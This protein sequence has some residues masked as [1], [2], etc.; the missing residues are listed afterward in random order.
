MSI[1]VLENA[2]IWLGGYDLSGQL[3]AV[4]IGLEADKHDATVFGCDGWRS[5]VAGLKS[6]N[7]G[8]VGFWEVNNDA[9]IMNNLTTSSAPFSTALLGVTAGN[10]AYCFNARTGT[11]NPYDANVGEPIK[12]TANA[13]AASDKMARGLLLAAQAIT[14]DGSGTAFQLGAV[15][16]TKKLCAA[17]HVTAWNATSLVVTLSSSSTEG[18]SYTVRGTF[19]TATAISGKWLIP[20]SGP[21]TDTWWKANWDITG[22][23]ATIAVVAGIE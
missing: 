2:K 11:Y 8:V 17:L 14:G 21:I 5:T 16:A 12:F 10:Q 4:S 15:A 20:V 1:V 13:F 23:S 18:G 22:T 7:A 19:A 6:L 9:A 3:N